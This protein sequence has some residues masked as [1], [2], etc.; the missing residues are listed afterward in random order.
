MYLL[1]ILISLLLVAG[2]SAYMSVF[3]LVSVFKGYGS[4]IVCMGL[5]METGKILTV[6]YVYRNWKTL[7]VLSRNLYIVIVAVLVLLTSVEI[8][9]F[10]AQSHVTTTHDL[11][12]FESALRALSNEE[13]VLREQISVMDRTLAGLPKT[14][15][16]RRIQERKAFGYDKKHSRLLE[17]GKG[18]AQLESNI[19]KAKQDAGPIFAVARI[20]RINETNAISMLILLLVVVLEPLSIGLT[21]AV[22]AAW[23]RQR[24]VPE[25]KLKSDISIGALNE[26][27]DQY[28]LS[29]DQLAKITGRKKT[30][31]CQAWLN[32]TTPVPPRAL[33]AV[34]KWVE[35]QTNT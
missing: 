34:E 8:V 1:I 14:Y 11:R 33:K 2:S 31:T 17:I 20:M 21:V 25:M 9:G 18:K 3:G 15:V 5:G 10:L 16:T 28:H 35:K 26:I 30:K 6:S 29:A 32:G 22:S 13:T 27:Q 24:I 4:I 23:T 7:S 12:M 19:I